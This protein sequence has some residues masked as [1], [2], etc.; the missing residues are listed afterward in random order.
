MACSEYDQA[1][2]TYSIICDEDGCDGGI[3][4][5]ATDE[6]TAADAVTN[7]EDWHAYYQGC[8]D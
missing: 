3:V 6:Y 2:D 1:D 4:E 7:H 8:E 5:F